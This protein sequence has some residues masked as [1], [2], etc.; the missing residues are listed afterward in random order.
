MK[1]DICGRKYDNAHS[2]G[3]GAFLTKKY[4][5]FSYFSIKTFIVGNTHLKQVL[6]YTHKVYFYAEI[7][8]ILCGYPFLS[9]GFNASL[10]NFGMQIFINAPYVIHFLCLCDKETLP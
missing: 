7:R 3:Q 10:T 1:C 6:L 5:Y 8:K 4:R 2:S 9:R